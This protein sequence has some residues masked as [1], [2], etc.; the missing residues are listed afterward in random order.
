MSK[1]HGLMTFVI[2]MFVQLWNS[3][4]E[5]LKTAKQKIICTKVCFVKKKKRFK[6][7]NIT[8][9]ESK[10]NVYQ[11]TQQNLHFKHTPYNKKI[12]AAKE[13]T[14]YKNFNSEIIFFGLDWEEI[15]SYGQ[16]HFRETNN[17]L[18]KVSIA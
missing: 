18:C 4:S 11:L 5:K 14:D 10:E 1:L 12:M 9:V 15:T 6:F 7:I 13:W 8:I 17:R 3:F 2:H 16:K